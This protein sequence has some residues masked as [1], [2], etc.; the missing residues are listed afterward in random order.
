[1]FYKLSFAKNIVF[2]KIIS[3]YIIYFKYE[4]KDYKKNKSK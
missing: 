2:Y 1:M 4:K 3:Q